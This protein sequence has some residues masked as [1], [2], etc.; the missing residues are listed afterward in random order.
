MPD[1]VKIYAADIEGEITACDDIK[2]YR[3]GDAWKTQVA[4]IVERNASKGLSSQILYPM[5]ITGVEARRSPAQI[6]F[7]NG[8]QPIWQGDDTCAPGTAADDY[9]L[10]MERPMSTDDGIDF[11]EL[12]DNQIEPQEEPKPPHRDIDLNQ[13]PESGKPFPREFHIASSSVKDSYYTVK[14]L[15]ESSGIC[16]CRGFSYRNRCRHLD[17]ARNLIREEKAKKR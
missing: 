11:L 5:S 8:Y 15:D 17:I 4:H 13:H 10:N 14:M 9:P 16:H 2:H 12:L 6:A 7:D 3:A 1:V